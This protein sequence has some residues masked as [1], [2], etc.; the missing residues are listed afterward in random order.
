MT[1][2]S[3]AGIQPA[4]ISLSNRR[5]YWLRRLQGVEHNKDNRIILRFN[6]VAA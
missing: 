1:D 4:N 5:M 3:T 2:T 6:C